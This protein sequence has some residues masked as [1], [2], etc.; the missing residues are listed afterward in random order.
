MTTSDIVTKRGLLHN[1][2][3]EELSSSIDTI[4][5]ITTPYN[6]GPNDIISSL[7]STALIKQDKKLIKIIIDKK[8]KLYDKNN[9]KNYELLKLEELTNFLHTVIS[10]KLDQ[11]ATLHNLFYLNSLPLNEIGK[12]IQ[13]ECQLMQYLL[14]CPDTVLLTIMK[15][16]NINLRPTI[17][18][19]KNNNSYEDII[20]KRVKKAD[21]IANLFD[22]LLINKNEQALLDYYLHTFIVKPPGQFASHDIYSKNCLFNMEDYEDCKKFSLNSF[23]ILSKKHPVVTAQILS[24]L[25]A[26]KENQSIEKIIEGTLKHWPLYTLSN[27][28][29]DSKATI[30]YMN[31]YGTK[32]SAAFLETN[33]V[34]EITNN[35]D[36]EIIMKFIELHNMN[37]WDIIGYMSKLINYYMFRCETYDTECNLI[38]KIFNKS[39]T[40]ASDYGEDFD[41]LMIRM[42]SRMPTNSGHDTKQ[43]ITRELKAL[44]FLVTKLAKT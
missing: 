13:T 12:H 34:G 23:I 26:F 38:T 1:N 40:K 9:R 20:I 5:D 29:T 41:K 15:H 21:D 32:T 27:K 3:Y 14:L 10:K 4:S 25:N 24:K 19:L 7:L 22:Q 16:L 33:F 2:T 39:K 28:T 18:Q 37:N 35:G 36:E 43:H 6:Q 31:I 17:L 11:E 8:S 30:D 44:G 42:L